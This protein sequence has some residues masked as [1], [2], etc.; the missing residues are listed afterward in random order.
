MK[1]PEMPFTPCCGLSW[2]G[3]KLPPAPAS[4]MEA[5]SNP[6]SCTSPPAPVG[7]LGGQLR[8]AA[9]LGIPR[10]CRRAGLA[11]RW[12]PPGSEPPCSWKI[13]SFKHLFSPRPRRARTA[14]GWMPRAPAV[15]RA[16]T[17]GPG[18]LQAR[19]RV[20]V[21]PRPAPARPPDEG[22]AIQPA[23]SG[24]VP[25]VGKGPH[26]DRPPANREGTGTPRLA[27]FRL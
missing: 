21:A 16:H 23:G 25:R 12:R 13:P 10:L 5:G 11:Q 1:Q 9:W 4:P 26:G 8:A 15:P 7:V 27:S 20:T 22:A 6:G 14:S 17:G 24:P 18:P 3:F 2:P 19:L